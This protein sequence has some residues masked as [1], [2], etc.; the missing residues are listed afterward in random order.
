MCWASGDPHYKTFDDSYYTFSGVCEYTL[1]KGTDFEVT[2]KT[3]ISNTGNVYRNSSKTLSYTV[4]SYFKKKKLF[5]IFRTIIHTLFI[6]LQPLYEGCSNMNATA[7]IT[8]KLWDGS[9]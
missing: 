7:F 4:F 9:S 6:V 1:A 3:Y 5:Y 8:Q 2:G